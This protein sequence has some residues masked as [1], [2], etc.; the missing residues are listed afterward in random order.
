M[1]VFYDCRDLKMP[2][3]EV[4]SLFRLAL[5]AARI[6]EIATFHQGC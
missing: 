2:A 3:E 4:A 6:G 1:K 5:A